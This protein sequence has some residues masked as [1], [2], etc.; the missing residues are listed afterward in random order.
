VIASKKTLLYKVTVQKVL[1][2]RP[3]KKWN[4]T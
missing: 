1:L 4:G 3:W 2:M